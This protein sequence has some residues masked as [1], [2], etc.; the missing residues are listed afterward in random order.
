MSKMKKESRFSCRT[1]QYFQG[2]LKRRKIV[3]FS[4][5]H[6]K[7]LPGSLKKEN[8]VK[9]VQNIKLLEVYTK[10]IFLLHDTSLF[11]RSE[12]LLD[13]CTKTRN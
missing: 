5:R 8:Q 11:L 7:F 9:Y 13:G 10:N 6:I 3:R 4:C 1:H 12:T 2:D